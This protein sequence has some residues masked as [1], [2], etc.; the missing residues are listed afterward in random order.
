LILKDAG[1]LLFGSEQLT[2][3]RREPDPLIDWWG[4]K[5][6]PFPAEYAYPNCPP[7]RPILWALQE[8]VQIEDGVASVEMVMAVY[9]SE[10]RGNCRVALPLQNRKS[11]LYQLREIGKL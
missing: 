10:L 9:E 11:Q 2:G 8:L 6:M 5:E 7:A 4:L 3:H 1:H